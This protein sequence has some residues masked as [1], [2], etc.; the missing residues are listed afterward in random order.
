M[1]MATIVRIPAPLDRRSHQP[2]RRFVAS[3]IALAPPAPADN[4]AVRRRQRDEQAA[5][6]V[7]RREE[8]ADHGFDLAASRPQLQ[9]LVQTPHA[10]FE[11]E[12]DRVLLLLESGE[13]ESGHHVGAEHLV[14]AP[15]AQL[16]DAATDCENAALLVA[17]DEA[18]R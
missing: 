13:S 3:S 5:V 15:A 2:L 12:L 6:V 18:G 17:G 16:E 9:V 10:P 14:L 8:V 7:E 4:L 11:R 1:P